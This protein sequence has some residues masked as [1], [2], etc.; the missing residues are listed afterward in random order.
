MR[1]LAD[2]LGLD[3]DH[4]VGW[5]W[6]PGKA[7]FITAHGATVFVGDHIHDV[8][9]ALAAGAISVSVLTGG[10]SEEEL[11]QA[12]TH[13]VLRELTEFPSW[14]DEHVLLTRLRAL[15]ADLTARGS[16]MVAFSG[17]ADS[18]FLLAA[19]VR[20]LGPANVVAATA[21]QQGPPAQA[22]QLAMQYSQTQYTQTQP[23]PPMQVQYMPAQSG[24]APVTPFGAPPQPA[25]AMGPWG[26]GGDSLEG[27]ASAS[28]PW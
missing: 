21:Y 16:V 14:L 2:A 28:S 4:L 7:E 11:R 19:A 24:S 6:G 25:G 3:V 18:A 15:E 10:C 12:G 5:A 27:S 26:Y 9:G 23:M 22:Q 17:G 8:E 20:A 13:V 1:P